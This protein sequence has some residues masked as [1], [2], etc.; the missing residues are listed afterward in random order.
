MRRSLI[1]IPTQSILAGIPIPA[2]SAGRVPLDYLKASP[3][4]KARAA[5][6]NANQILAEFSV[7]SGSYSVPVPSHCSADLVTDSKEAHA[8][9]FRPFPGLV[10]SAA[11]GTKSVAS[12]QAVIQS[13]IDAGA[14]EEAQ[15]LSVDLVHIGRDGLRYFQT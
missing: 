13:S 12:H 2:N 10:D 9:A 7:R 15:R 6:A 1:E 5:F 3:S 11:T 8:I 14:Y 4:F